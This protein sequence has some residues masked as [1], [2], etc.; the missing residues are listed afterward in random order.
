MFKPISQTRVAQRVVEQIV[1]LVR[2]GRLKP[3]DRLPGENQLAMEFRVSRPCVREAL[4]IL[5]AV[6]IVEVQ[7]GKGCYV[8]GS[9][10]G[11]DSGA[12]WRSW[13]SSFQG[14]VLALLEVRE[15]VEAK[16]AALAAE[17]ASQSHLDELQAVVSRGWELWEAGRLGPDEAYAL[18]LRFHEILARASGN[19]FLLRLSTS[20]GG[21]LEADRRATMD[22]P[23]RIRSSLEDHAAILEAVKRKDGAGAAEKMIVHIRA[24]ARDISRATEAG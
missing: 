3:G 14:E 16:V 12:L 13:L 24:V 2:S 1:E 17:R 4:R 19:P 21:A 22:I 9:P 23:N 18:D 6:G 8:L 20:V 10:D 15:A 5:E 11:I 7:R